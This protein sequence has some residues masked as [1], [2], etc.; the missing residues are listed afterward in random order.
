MIHNSRYHKIMFGCRAIIFML[1]EIQGNLERC[2][3]VSL[4]G[5]SFAG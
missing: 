1:L 4:E 5:R 3:M 2:L